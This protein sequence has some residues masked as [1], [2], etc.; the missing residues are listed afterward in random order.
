[1]DK[2]HDIIEQTKLRPVIIN[3]HSDFVM[4]TYWWGR[5]N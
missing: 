5:G 4:I 1:M 3:K 2:L